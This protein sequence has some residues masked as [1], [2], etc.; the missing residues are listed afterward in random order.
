MSSAS[1]GTDLAR[2]GNIDAGLFG[3]TTDEARTKRLVRLL[4][5][6]SSS[7][8]RGTSYS[9]PGCATSSVFES[10]FMDSNLARFGLRSALGLVR[11]T[12]SVSGDA[13]F[14]APVGPAC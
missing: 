11:R 3:D 14:F 2:G 4:G 8:R 13:R 1:K 12:G 7:S 10:T 9:I 5:L 6:V